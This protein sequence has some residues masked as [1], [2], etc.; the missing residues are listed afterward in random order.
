MND[1]LYICRLNTLHIMNTTVKSAIQIGVIAGITGVIYTL[2][3]YVMGI[4]MFSSFWL[5]LLHIPI[6][7]GFQL[8]AAFSQRKKNG[9]YLTYKDSYLSMF[10]VG[11]IAILIGVLFNIL[12][13]NVINTGLA[14]E[15][16][17]V[18]MQ[19][20]L[21]W[22]EKFGTPEEAITEAMTEMDKTFTDSFTVAGL[23]KGILGQTIFIGVLSLLFALIPKRLP[24][25]TTPAN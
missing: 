23:L 5:S 8:W 22:M 13:F 4:E 2:L 12:L 3:R 14:E 7:I 18:T 25:N 16:K 24:E 15:M 9:G 21:E 11:V 10:T 17:E 19:K 6:T 1:A 20:T